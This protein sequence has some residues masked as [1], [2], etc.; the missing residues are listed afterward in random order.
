MGDKKE[1]MG[2]VVYILHGWSYSTEKWKPFL[3]LLEQT[4]TDYQLLKIPGLTAPLSNVWDL[5]D[6]VTWL[7]KEVG[8]TNKKIVLMGH[9]N[10]GRIA[11]AFA[12]KYPQKVACLILIDSAGMIRR[13]I[14]TLIK[15]NIFKLLSTAGKKITKSDKVRDL[16]YKIIGEHDYNEANETV[17]K[18]ML[19]LI[20]QDLMETFSNI[21][22][23]TLIIWGKNDSTTPLSCGKKIHSLIKGSE[24]VIIPDAKHSPQFTNASE[25]AALVVSFSKQYSNSSHEK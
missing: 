10:G 20:S 7:K 18:T 15:K 17:K 23:P 24:L 25:V 12:E 8:K 5:Q 3:K 22:I 16:I 13:D 2:T 21:I 19:S 11:S 9:S 6:Y 4:E 1:E 14:K